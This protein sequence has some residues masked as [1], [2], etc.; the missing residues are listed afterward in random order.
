VPPD[1]DVVAGA[2]LS[3]TDARAARVAA[4]LGGDASL[5]LSAISWQADALT[6]DNTRPFCAIA[7][8][9]MQVSRTM[10]LA[11]SIG[12]LLSDGGRGGGHPA[13]YSRKPG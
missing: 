12:G 9:Q 4:S 10:K 3:R 8:A 13:E 11:R 5:A 6:V 1:D 7:G 2:Y